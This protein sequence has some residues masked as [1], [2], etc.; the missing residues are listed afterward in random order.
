M[1][2]A[3]AVEAGVEAVAGEEEE[4]LPRTRCPSLLP[5]LFRRLLFSVFS[6]FIKFNKK[7]NNQQHFGNGNDIFNTIFCI[8]YVD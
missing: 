1:E 5:T 7:E 8:L 2:V 3:E 4:R 6:I